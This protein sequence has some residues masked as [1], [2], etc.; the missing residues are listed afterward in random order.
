[1]IDAEEIQHSIDNLRAKPVKWGWFQKWRHKMIWK[2]LEKFIIQAKWSWQTTLIGV[3]AGLPFVL[4]EMAKLF[5]G[6]TATT[7]DDGKL[8]YGLGLMGIG[9]FSKTRSTT[10]LAP[11]PPEVPS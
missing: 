2:L 5:D 10:G 7:V 9:W 8:M 11:K 1:M 4:A 3:I 6:D